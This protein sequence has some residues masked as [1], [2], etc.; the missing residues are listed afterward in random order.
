LNHPQ[1]SKLSSVVAMFARTPEAEDWK[2]PA[3]VLAEVTEAIEKERFRFVDL[4]SGIRLGY[5]ECGDPKSTLPLVVFVHG[6]P[7]TLWTW[8]NA[9]TTLAGKGFYCVSMA[10]R[11]YYPSSIPAIKPEE[12]DWQRYGKHLLARDVLGLVKALKVRWFISFECPSF[13]QNKKSV[14][15]LFLWVMILGR[16]QCG[17]PRSSIRKKG[18]FWCRKLLEKLFLRQKVISL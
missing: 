15:V 10:Q 8:D 4:D 18:L 12:A 13:Q 9:M 17:P 1:L 14:L 16:L 11:G 5:I 3:E 6:F 7:D 2:P